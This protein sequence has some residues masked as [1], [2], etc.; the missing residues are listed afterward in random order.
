VLTRQ[1][2][3]LLSQS[4][5]APSTRRVEHSEVTTVAEHPAVAAGPAST[6]QEHTEQVTQSATGVEHHERST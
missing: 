3:P 5:D 6:T 4:S 1:K 2:E